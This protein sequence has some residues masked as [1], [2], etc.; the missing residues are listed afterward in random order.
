MGVG[1]S[2]RPNNIRVTDKIMCANKVSISEKKACEYFFKDLNNS[3][4]AVLEK[5][6]QMFLDYF[7]SIDVEKGR[8]TIFYTLVYCGMLRLR[9]SFSSKQSESIRNYVSRALAAENF[10]LVQKELLHAH[11]T[12]DEEMYKSSPEHPLENVARYLYLEIGMPLQRVKFGNRIL[13]RPNLA[14]VY[15]ME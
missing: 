10:H 1:R 11:E 9:E 6:S 4:N 12:W 5:L 2:I 15:V 14:V 13:D 3:A 8:K 7:K